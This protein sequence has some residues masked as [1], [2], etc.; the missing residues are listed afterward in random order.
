MMEARKRTTK[1]LVNTPFKKII[2]GL[3]I[4]SYFLIVGSPV[5]G[6]ILGKWM[7][8]STAQTGGLIL[9]VFIVGEIL[10]YGT[11]LFLGKEVVLLVKDRAK[12]LFKRK[13]EKPND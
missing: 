4:L 11:L 9:G 10:F 7:G 12:D 13:K 3:Q 2:F 5:I 1:D 6:G 8:L